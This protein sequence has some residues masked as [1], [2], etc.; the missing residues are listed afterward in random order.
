MVYL[1]GYRASVVVVEAE[2]TNVHFYCRVVRQEYRQAR[3]KAYI[4][5]EITLVGAGNGVARAGYEFRLASAYLHL[6]FVEYAEACAAAE[7]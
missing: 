6:H 7:A 2:Y 5:L 1:V 4:E 3:C